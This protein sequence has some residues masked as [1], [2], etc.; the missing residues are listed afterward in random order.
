[1]LRLLPDY[2]NACGVF[3]QV[4]RLSTIPFIKF[5]ELRRRGLVYRER[6][7]RARHLEELGAS[8]LFACRQ[9]ARALRKI[10]RLYFESESRGTVVF[11]DRFSGATYEF[12]TKELWPALRRL[13]R[14]STLDVSSTSDF[15]VK[16]VGDSLRDLMATTYGEKDGLRK[17]RRLKDRGFWEKVVLDNS[18]RVV[19]AARIDFSS[20]G[21][22]VLACWSD[23]PMF[24]ASPNYIA[25][26]LAGPKEE[27]FLCMWL[28]SSYGVLQL[29]PATSATRGSWTRI[30]RFT[31]DRMWIP[32]FH[33]FSKDLWERSERLWA[34][35]SC[36]DVTSLVGQLS[37][38]S[39]FRRVLDQGLIDLLGF[40]E[41]SAHATS[42]E[43]L[44]KGLASAILALRE[45]MGSGRKP[46]SDEVAE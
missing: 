20:P 22:T 32:D 23:R 40:K 42:G 44:R 45:S 3:E 25:E 38:R 12:E 27:H 30:E 46:A 16:V 15:C 41:E 28:N 13:A 6:I 24:L 2:D 39:K 9:K 31:L 29:L 17:W 33:A 7:E 21:T 8:A 35:T 26:G 36:M 5:A 1:M 11:R 43:T 10:D 4:R 18:A 37:Q 14:V 19:V 34:N